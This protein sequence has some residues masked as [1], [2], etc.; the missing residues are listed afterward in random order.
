MKLEN[1]LM[2]PTKINSEW[3][4][5]LNVRPETIKFLGGNIGNNLTDISF[6]N[7]L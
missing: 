6:K 3:I 7:D 1:Y 4:K 5:I 2:P